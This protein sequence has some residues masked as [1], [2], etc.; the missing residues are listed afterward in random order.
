M[1]GF[2]FN[3]I[4]D[5]SSIAV[6]PVCPR[7]HSCLLFFSL[8][9]YFSIFI[10]HTHRVQHR[11]R[12]ARVQHSY[13]SSRFIEIKFCRTHA[14]AFSN[15]QV[16][17]KY[18]CFR[19]GTRRVSNPGHCG[20]SH[21]RSDVAN[22]HT[23]CAH[24][25]IWHTLLRCLPFPGT[26]ACQCYRRILPGDLLCSTVENLE[27]SKS[28]HIHCLLLTKTPDVSRGHYCSALFMV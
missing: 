11:S 8:S 12:T 25:N 23:Y 24:E 22:F 20:W 5:Y 2:I 19:L 21:L 10:A 16:P 27:I 7:G 1:E 17:R 3:G 4:Q 18:I 6:P 14:R 9:T 28:S 26:V 15:N 13:C